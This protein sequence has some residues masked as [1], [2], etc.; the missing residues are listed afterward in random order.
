MYGKGPFII[1]VSAGGTL[2]KSRIV[3]VAEQ[4]LTEHNYKRFGIRLL[5]DNGFDVEYWDVTNVLFHKIMPN[6]TELDTVNFLYNVGIDFKNARV[7]Y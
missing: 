2:G 7:F 4:C 3:F 5:R 6:L 1:V